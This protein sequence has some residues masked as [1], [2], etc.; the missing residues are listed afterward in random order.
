MPKTLVILDT[1]KNTRLDTYYESAL[2]DELNFNIHELGYDN[3]E[4]VSLHYIQQ[5]LEETNNHYDH[6]L[7]LA[8]GEPGALQDS[9]TTALELQDILAKGFLAYKRRNKTSKLKHFY[10]LG[11]NGVNTTN[12]NT[13]SLHE[14]TYK[15]FKEAGIT[16]VAIV[17][18]Q[19]ETTMAYKLFQANSCIPELDNVVKEL[20]KT[21]DEAS[22]VFSEIHT[23]LS[24]AIN[25]DSSVEEKQKKLRKCFASTEFQDLI[26]KLN[27]FFIEVTRRQ[28]PNIE[29]S[30]DQESQ[31]ATYASQ[32]IQER[33]LRLIANRGNI[34]DYTL[35]IVRLESS[36]YKLATEFFGFQS[37]K[38][39]DN[40]EVENKFQDSLGRHVVNS[41]DD[42]YHVKL[43][44]ITESV[45]VDR[46]DNLIE[47][48]KYLDD[49]EAVFALINYACVALEIQDVSYHEK[50]NQLLAVA[51][52]QLQ[53][54]MKEYF[55]NGP[56]KDNKKVIQINKRRSTLKEFLNRVADND[57][58]K[59]NIIALDQYLLSFEIEFKTKGKVSNLI[60]LYRTDNQ[61]ELH[62]EEVF[63]NKFTNIINKLSTDLSGKDINKTLKA[64]ESLIQ[65]LDVINDPEK[66]N[67]CIK[68]NLLSNINLRK[69]ETKDM[70]SLIN[71]LCRLAEKNYLLDQETVK[72]IDSKVLSLIKAMA[73]KMINN[74]IDLLKKL[75]DISQT[76][77]GMEAQLPNSCNWLIENKEKAKLK[78]LEQLEGVLTK[79]NTLEF[80]NF[81]ELVDDLKIV[82]KAQVTNDEDI[83][84]CVSKVVESMCTTFSSN[85]MACA[86]TTE[87][88]QFITN[89]NDY[90][91]E[92]AEKAN[93]NEK[94]EICNFI[95]S[96]L[97]AYENNLFNDI[98]DYK[99]HDKL[100]TCIRRTLEITD[101]NN[102]HVEYFN[103][104][105]NTLVIIENAPTSKTSISKENLK[106]YTDH[107]SKYTN[108]NEYI[109]LLNYAAKSLKEIENDSELR[110]Q[111]NKLFQSVIDKLKDHEYTFDNI[112]KLIPILKTLPF[113][114]LSVVST[115]KLR[116]FVKN[117]DETIENVLT[118][119]EEKKKNNN[120]EKFKEDYE[121]DKNFI[122]AELLKITPSKKEK[123]KSFTDFERERIKKQKKESD[124]EIAPKRGSKYF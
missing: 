33:Y 15:A 78:A 11:C 107:I 91:I 84:N 68:T 104:L 113:N 71:N 65:V 35:M 57:A 98:S 109:L 92:I 36:I 10:W 41:S 48:S 51:L 8:H 85:V 86:I 30:E 90:L 46:L 16:E 100:S 9:E 60:K 75:I 73:S 61:L 3:V 54:I 18:Y 82:R 43:A 111:A 64:I 110:K 94:Q 121:T 108:F 17:G 40:V 76:I 97:K 88:E 63:R 81:E 80:I 122:T 103:N 32:E 117:L 19:N 72:L 13:L 39:L 120:L 115:A 12:E 124:I 118:L 67:T 79:V 31:F 27:K 44:T 4:V 77:N 47:V 1:P 20:T 59:A 112:K 106:A 74:P 29:I 69:I 83:Q 53:S 50:A 24:T 21:S 105:L 114:S 56:D 37:D 99:Y 55:E 58:A 6:V 93:D 123:R 66:I 96:V 22:R 28:N 5:H 34:K 89:C 102:P 52:S 95:L 45:T 2:L 23:L 70:I 49:S 25:N 26:N 7:L 119:E 116:D 42:A 62:E 14:A 87:P 38:S 101:N